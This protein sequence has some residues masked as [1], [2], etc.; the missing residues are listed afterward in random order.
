MEILGLLYITL[1]SDYENYRLMIYITIKS[2]PS[3]AVPGVQKIRD[4]KL[5][6]KCAI[7]LVIIAYERNRSLSDW[8][9]RFSDVMDTLRIAASTGVIEILEIFFKYCKYPINAFARESLFISALRQRQDK[10]F[11]FLLRRCP[12][13]RSD[14]LVIDLA[15][16]T[17]LHKAAELSDCPNIRS[18]AGAAFQ[19]QKE[20]QW[21]KV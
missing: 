6:H 8:Q 10:V 11:N 9:S 18:I 21:F 13:F 7:K 15:E 20:L 19:M 1:I 17:T 4:T 12:G 16:T 3:L 2:F 5:R 14:L